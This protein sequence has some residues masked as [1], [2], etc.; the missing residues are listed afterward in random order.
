MLRWML[1]MSILCTWVVHAN[2]PMAE[3]QKEQKQAIE[4][5]LS[6][7]ELTFE[8]QR[9]G[10]IYTQLI[11]QN[12]PDQSRYKD[13]VCRV[14]IRLHPSGSVRR[15]VILP[16]STNKKSTNQELLCNDVFLTVYRLK[17]FPMPKQANLKEK[18]QNIN[19]TVIP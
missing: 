14:N 17:R 2:E 7:M 18:L 16:P 15:V 13:E 12:L 3:Q 6:P 11:S 5:T 4:R 8:A 19:L 9:W 10:A 1:A